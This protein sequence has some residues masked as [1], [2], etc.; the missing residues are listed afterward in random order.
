MEI[1][2]ILGFLTNIGGLIYCIYSLSKIHKRIDAIFT[3][4]KP[5]ANDPSLTKNVEENFQEENF[6]NIPPNVKFEIEGG[7]SNVPPGYTEK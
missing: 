7:D 2:I 6:L 4:D 3:I 5:S 1:V